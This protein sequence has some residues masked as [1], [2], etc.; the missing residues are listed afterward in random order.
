M[1]SVLSNCGQ[2]SVYR[3]AETAAER[4]ADLAS[5]RISP[6][7]AF[8]EYAFDLGAFVLAVHR[9]KPEQPFPRAVAGNLLA[10]ISG[11]E[12]LNCAARVARRTLADIGHRSR[13]SRRHVDPMPELRHAHADFASG[14]PASQAPPPSSRRVAPAAKRGPGRPDVHAVQACGRCDIIADV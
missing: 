9:V 3:V 1:I 8:R 10:T 12:R 5:K 13:T 11:R 14:T 6:T 2:A 4:A 7:V